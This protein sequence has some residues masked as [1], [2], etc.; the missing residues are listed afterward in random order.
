VRNAY[1]SSFSTT[2]LSQSL[3]KDVGV[4]KQ[5]LI[6]IY[7]LRRGPNFRLNVLRE[8]DEPAKELF[9]EKVKAWFCGNI[10]VS[11]SQFMSNWYIHLK[12]IPSKSI[13]HMHCYFLAQRAALQKRQEA[14]P[15]G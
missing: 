2:T 3:R 8:T 6:K 14:I 10:K 15:S 12:L 11:R 7:A 1:H 9:A 4:Q 5:K 13:Y